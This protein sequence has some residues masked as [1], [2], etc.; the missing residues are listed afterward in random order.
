MN[1]DLGALERLTATSEPPER[2]LRPSKYDSSPRYV[3]GNASGAG[4]GISKW[5]PGDTHINVV[6]GAWNKNVSRGSSFNFQELANLVYEIEKMD[7]AHKLSD[8]VQI[9]IFTNNQH[10]ESAFYRGM[11]ISPE[12]LELM[13]RLHLILIKGYAFVHVV[14]VAG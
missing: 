8:Q 6:H 13:F 4:F 14:W 5:G 1:F 11:A 12:V 7:A 10:A 2:G 9:F 3:F